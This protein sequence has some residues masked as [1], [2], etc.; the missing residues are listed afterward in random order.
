MGRLCACSVLAIASHVDPIHM[1]SNSKH[2]AST[3]L[4]Q[5][6]SRAVQDLAGGRIPD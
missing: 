1:G 4:V 3:E 6:F 5:S 2:R